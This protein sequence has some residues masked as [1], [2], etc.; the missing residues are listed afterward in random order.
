MILLLSIDGRYQF[1]G[2]RKDIHKITGFLVV[3]GLHQLTKHHKDMSQ[4]Q[5]APEASGPAPS[6]A[7]KEG[8]VHSTFTL[9]IIA[10]LTDASNFSQ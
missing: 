2:L 9:S 1:L 8:K 10:V 5:G 3:G 6:T 7:E 4:T